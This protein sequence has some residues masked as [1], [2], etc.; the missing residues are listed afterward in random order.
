MANN[1][2]N[3]DIIEIESTME[4]IKIHLRR[5][6]EIVGIGVKENR[7][8][9]SDVRFLANQM[10]YH[11]SKIDNNDR[12]LRELMGTVDFIKEEVLKM[13]N[14]N[15]CSHCQETSDHGNH[16]MEETSVMQ[17]TRKLEGKKK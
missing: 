16:P 11:E 5:V 2:G 4:D 12:D 10:G 7:V 17:L 9:A 3:L 6:Y 1:L 14:M 13:V 15:Q 8:V